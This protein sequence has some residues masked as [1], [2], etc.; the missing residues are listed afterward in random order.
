MI[1]LGAG[2]GIGVGVGV[3]IWAIGLS[4]ALIA[5]PV[6]VAAAGGFAIAR[7]NQRRIVTRA[8]LALEQL[9]DALERGEIRRQPDSLLG[10]IVAAATQIP[11]RRF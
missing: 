3:A 4:T 11:P 8:Q 1:V 10:A 5:A 2:V 9:L 6:V 7:A